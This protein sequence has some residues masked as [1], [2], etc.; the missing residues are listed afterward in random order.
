MDASACACGATNPRFFSS[1]S[2][3]LRASDGVTSPRA[4]W[5]RKI[6][7]AA[8][9]DAAPRTMAGAEAQMP[10]IRNLASSDRK[11]RT[12]SLAALQTYLSTRTGLAATEAR[13]LWTGLYYALWMTDGPRP[14]QALASDL[15][16]LPLD[17]PGACAVPLATGFWDVMSRQWASIDALRMDKFLLLVRRAFAAQVRF[18]RREGWFGPRVEQM[19]EL[20]RRRAFDADDEDGAPLGLRLH[21]LDLW[22]DELDRERALGRDEDEDDDDDAA[23]ARDRW[24][25]EVGDMVDALRA[26]P[27]KSVRNRAS[28][29]YADERLPWGARRSDDEGH[30]EVGLEDEAWDGIE[31]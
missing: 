2:L 29:S 20:W 17:A 3:N 26:S 7:A 25:R 13:K 8:D 6:A 22:V 10:F 28:E 14:Q 24:V 16:R 5:K 30:G 21:V 27:V 9:D 19:L 1:T 18:A 23:A 11:L 4:I 31:D 12:Q 15:A